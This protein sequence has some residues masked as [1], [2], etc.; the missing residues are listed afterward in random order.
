MAFT[1]KKKNNLKQSQPF[2]KPNLDASLF[3][4]PCTTA[5]WT[6]VGLMATRVADPRRA[7]AARGAIKAASGAI[8]V[9]AASRP[10]PVPPPPPP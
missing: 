8:T 7:R 6:R 9:P 1:F 5:N 10:T 3:F 4:L 2:T